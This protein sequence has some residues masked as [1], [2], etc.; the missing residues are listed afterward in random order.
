MA[1]AS[2]NA[3]DD[4]MREVRDRALLLG[5]GKEYLCAP[6]FLK[7]YGRELGNAL[8]ALQKDIQTLKKKFP[9]RFAQEVDTDRILEG[10]RELAQR[11]EASDAAIQ[12]QCAAGRIG[13]DLEDRLKT[14]SDAVKGVRLQVEG[15][16][17]GYTGTEAVA[18]AVLRA[19]G[20]F[21]GGLGWTVKALGFLLL[22][23]I[24]VFFFLFFTM[25]KEAKYI[26][27]IER[28]QAQVKQL[29]NDLAGIESR[30][31]PLEERVKYMEGR[32]LTREE[33]LRFMEME[34][35]L[36]KLEKKARSTEG[37][38]DQHL[39]TIQEAEEDLRRLRQ[40]GFL[41]RLLH[42]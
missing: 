18:G 34:L 6:P 26:T 20:A 28:N 30:L 23:G 36:R 9:G 25:E 21:R 31:T 2:E 40:K 42:Q 19:G 33:K 1:A 41:E 22:L 10:M 37:E 32:I 12:E 16:P 39:H 3:F 24:G 5:L 4:A 8:S 11:L 7:K 38:I 14:L 13:Q 35:A 27:S 15:A 17:R 29:Q